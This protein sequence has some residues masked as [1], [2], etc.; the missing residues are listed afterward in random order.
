MLRTFHHLTRA[1]RPPGGGRLAGCLL[2][3]MIS[4]GILAASPHDALIVGGTREP[5][6]WTFANRRK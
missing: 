5:I 4:G 6:Y 1:A 3:A 2:T